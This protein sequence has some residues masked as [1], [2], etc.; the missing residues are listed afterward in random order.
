LD[1]GSLIDSRSVP[2][3]CRLVCHAINL[4][5]FNLPIPPFHV[6][7]SSLV[8]ACSPRSWVAPHGTYTFW[9]RRLLVV[10][11]LELTCSRLTR[12]LRPIH[13]VHRI[14]A[15]SKI[16]SNSLLKAP[17]LM[18]HI[19]SAKMIRYGLMGSLNL[20]FPKPLE[21]KPHILLRLSAFLLLIYCSLLK[22]VSDEPA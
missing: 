9:N 21:A 19:P 7:M 16:V 3:S 4:R 12:Y 10:I 11:Y 2:V 14:K 20:G 1:Q 18:K 17:M 5:I 22:E 6:G 13:D 8:F 15:L